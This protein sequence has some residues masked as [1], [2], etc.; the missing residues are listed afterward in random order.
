MKNSLKFTSSDLIDGYCTPEVY[1]NQF[2]TARKLEVGKIYY[3]SNI[4]RWAESYYKIVFT[5]E[6]IAV[7][8]QVSGTSI[9]A[10]GS[11]KYCIFNNKGHSIGWKYQDSRSCYRLQ[12]VKEN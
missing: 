12:E 6:N 1:Y 3:Q 9:K 2:N 5:D 8:V 11:G 7:G 4:G 10:G